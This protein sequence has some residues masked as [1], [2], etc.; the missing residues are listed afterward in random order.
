MTLRC[1]ECEHEVV[2]PGTQ[3]TAA[4]NVLT[5]SYA[6]LRENEDY[7][8][9]LDADVVYNIYG[10]GN[11]PAELEQS[12]NVHT[13][14]KPALLVESCQPAGEATGVVV[15]TMVSLVLNQEVSY[16]DLCVITVRPEEAGASVT[17]LHATAAA[18]TANHTFTVSGL[19]YFTRYLLEVPAGCFRNS[20]DIANDAM[21]FAFRT[22][23]ET[24]ALRDLLQ[25]GEY[26]ERSAGRAAGVYLQP[27][28]DDPGG[29]EHHGEGAGQA[30]G[31]ARYLRGGGKTFSVYN[32][33]ANDRLESRTSYTVYIPEGTVCNSDGLCMEAT[34]FL[35]FTTTAETASRLILQNTTPT[36]GATQV[37]ASSQ[38]VLHFSGPVRV[39]SGAPA[40]YVIYE[41]MRAVAG[42]AEF[43]GQD[44]KLTFPL[45]S[46]KTYTYVYDDSL[47]AST[48][49]AAVYYDIG[50]LGSSFTVADTEDLSAST[51]R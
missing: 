22:T 30:G 32:Q 17:L 33:A 4:D 45:K 50:L 31:V 2:V 37:A 13:S 14:E 35:P 48:R 26:G 42:T 9:I 29:S 40:E 11:A 8:I 36:P 49:G 38:V 46:G 3:L 28:P 5:V 7:V 1:K 20:F 21:G 16:D 27:G 39:S 6:G 15:N 43:A 25:P 44:V 24:G 47:F 41:D 10:N 51:S 23:Y 18:M 19:R 34:T 12:V